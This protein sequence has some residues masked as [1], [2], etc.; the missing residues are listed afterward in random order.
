[1]CHCYYEIISYMFVEQRVFHEVDGHVLLA[2]LQV[3]RRRPHDVG[4]HVLL[5]SVAWQ[6]GEGVTDEAP[7][8][9]LVVHAHDATGKDGGSAWGRNS[10]N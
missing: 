9:A 6:A 10:Y 7:P 4:P 5:I 8:V 3:A 2:D 1:M